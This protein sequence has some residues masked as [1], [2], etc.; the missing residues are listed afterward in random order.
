MS[1]KK[2]RTDLIFDVLTNHLK[3][4]TETELSKNQETSAQKLNFT[5]LDLETLKTKKQQIAY[6]SVKLR[7][8]VY[9]RLKKVAES[10]GIK[11]PGKLITLIVEAFLQ[12]VEAPLKNQEPDS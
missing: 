3:N 11:Q 5:N 7:M 6:A 8:D 12:E 1:S 4:G 9:E 10:Q 2:S